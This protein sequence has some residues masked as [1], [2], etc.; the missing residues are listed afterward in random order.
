[1]SGIVQMMTVSAVSQADSKGTV[2]DREFTVKSVGD[3]CW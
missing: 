3:W 2:A 1:M